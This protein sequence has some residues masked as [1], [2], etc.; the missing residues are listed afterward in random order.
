MAK[1][2]TMTFNH[3]MS[4]PHKNF[5]FIRPSKSKLK[6]NSPNFSIDVFESI[7]TILKRILTFGIKLFFIRIKFFFP[8]KSNSIDIHQLTYPFHKN[9]YQSTNSTL[10]LHSQGCLTSKL[11]DDINNHRYHS[12][13]TQSI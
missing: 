8:T 9:T 10:K 2:S 4:I 13:Y 7:L 5:R 6:F 11:I 12:D 3:S 1:H